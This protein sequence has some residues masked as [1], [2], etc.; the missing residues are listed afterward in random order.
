[1]KQCH[2]NND[3]HCRSRGTRW[4][5]RS[6]G[7]GVSLLSSFSLL[8]FDSRLTVGSLDDKSTTSM[9]DKYFSLCFLVIKRNYSHYND[10][11]PFRAPRLWLIL[12]LRYNMYVLFQY[13]P[14]LT[15]SRL[16]FF[17]TR[18]KS[19]AGTRLGRNRSWCYA[20]RFWPIRIKMCCPYPFG[21]LECHCCDFCYNLVFWPSGPP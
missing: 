13:I 16:P 15:P 5:L 8:S 4:P 1:M 21:N 2:V 7:P 10:T 9:Y 14:L 17:P 20:V 12:T 19:P 18:F 11:S 6:G 3:T